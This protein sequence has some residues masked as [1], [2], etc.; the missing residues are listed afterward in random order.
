MWGLLVV[1]L[2]LL[3]GCAPTPAVTPPRAAYVCSRTGQ[4]IDVD[5]RLDESPWQS[6]PRLKLDRVYQPV[7]YA[8]PPPATTVQLLWNEEYLFAAFTCRDADIW[9]FSSRPDDDLWLGDVVELF[10]KPRRE[11][12][13][14]MEFVVAPNGTLFDARYPSR[15]A[16]GARRFRG[17]A[18]DA[19]VGTSLQGT[20]GPCGDVDEGYSVEIAISWEA[21]LGSATS[22]RPG[23]RWS[24]GAFR[25]DYSAA[26]EDPWLLACIPTDGLKGFHDYEKYLTLVFEP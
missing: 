3:V 26:V 19:V 20:D 17:W 6:A 1:P 18:S 9:S 24:F 2:L 22:P 12:K 14:Y 13:G 4:Q 8:E 15:G 23:D 21:L 16:G 25:Y 10:F 11:A 5:G 7:S